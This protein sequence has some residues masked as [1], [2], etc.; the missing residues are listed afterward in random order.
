M[1]GWGIINLTSEVYCKES[2]DTGA[3]WSSRVLPRTHTTGRRFNGWEDRFDHC[4]VA[5]SGVPKAL[6]GLHSDCI[7]IRVFRGRAVLHSVPLLLSAPIG[8]TAIVVL[9]AAQ[10][11]KLRRI[12]MG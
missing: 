6:K 8:V 7:H 5:T 9:Q 12:V 4:L 3:A 11:V 10:V 1:L 2:Y